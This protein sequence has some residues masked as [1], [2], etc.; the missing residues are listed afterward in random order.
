MKSH[1]DVSSRPPI[2]DKAPST[3]RARERELL[4]AFHERRDEKALTELIRSHLPLVRAIVHRHR[5]RA[6]RDEDLLAEGNL[7]LL[8]AAMRFDP[9][10]DVRFATYATHWIRARVREHVLRFRRVVGG[11]DTRASRRILG[12]RGRVEAA[13]SQSLGRPADDHELAAALGVQP[14]D[15]E[16]VRGSYDAHD[17]P[18]DDGE[19]VLRADQASAEDLVGD[20][21]EFRL[22]SRAL[23]EAMATLGERERTIIERRQLSGSPT[24]LHVLA[25]ELSISRERV[26]QLEIRGLRAL[27]AAVGAAPLAATRP[28]NGDGASPSASV[29]RARTT[30]GQRRLSA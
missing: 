8:E 6:L 5:V 13:L 10:F 9:A 27:S 22:R 24:P 26:R 14:S 23:A 21:E 30:G 17:V 3:A 25:S 12:R 2:A 28:R 1:N 29:T 4:L 11:P 15:L 19:S 18:V 7:G 16:Q 20:S